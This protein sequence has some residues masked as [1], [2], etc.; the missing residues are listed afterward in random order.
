VKPIHHLIYAK[1]GSEAGKVYNENTLK[2][3]K[4]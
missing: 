2:F 3:F 4:S 1:E